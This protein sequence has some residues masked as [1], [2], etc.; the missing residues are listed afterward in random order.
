MFSISITEFGA[1]PYINEF[2]ARGYCHN[3]KSS[4]QEF[5]NFNQEGL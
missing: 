4:T 3:K 2:L 1:L 5:R